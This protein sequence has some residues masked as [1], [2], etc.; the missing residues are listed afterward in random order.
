MPLSAVW[1]TQKYVQ[2]YNRNLPARTLIFPVDKWAPAQVYLMVRD[3]RGGQRIYKNAIRDLG[4]AKGSVYVPTGGIVGLI[5][6]MEGVE[7]LSSLKKL[8][9]NDIQYIRAHSI[10]LQSSDLENI[11]H[12]KGL[13]QLDCEFTDLDDNALKIICRFKNME[14]LMLKH[15]NITDKH[16]EM[17]NK[18]P[19]LK[20]ISLD[21][22]SVTDNGIK[23]LAGNTTIVSIGLEGCKVTEQCINDLVKIRKLESIRIP[24]VSLTDDQLM[25]FAS[26]PSLWHIQIG[27]KKITQGGIDNFKAKR[28][29]CDVVRYKFKFPMEML[30]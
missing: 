22:C 18:M 16:I 30:F 25:R 4:P 27:N 29:N 3:I 17:L 26:L 12:L 11:V 13:E 8:K 15:C 28:P 20:N 14:T 19:K 21:Y 6:T 1:A 2:K 5:I 7:K 23:K 24:S 10:P 9:S